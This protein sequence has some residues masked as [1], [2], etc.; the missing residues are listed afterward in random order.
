MKVL[1]SLL[2]NFAGDLLEQDP[3]TLSEHSSDLGLSVEE[4]VTLGAAFNGV[5]VAKVLDLRPH[6]DADR[7]QLVDVDDGSGTARQ[8]CC[9]A[10]NMQVGDLVPLATDG[11]VV[12]GG[13]KI[14]HRKLRGEWSEGMLCSAEE[15]ELPIS[16]TE[17][18]ILILPG[19]AELGSNVSEALDLKHDVLFDLEVNPNRPD[20]MSVAGVARV[21]AARLGLSFSIP[22]PNVVE[23]AKWLSRCQLQLMSPISVGISL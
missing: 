14:K 17:P 23:I 20:A 10:F 16:N 18:E 3:N 15:L 12:A 11:A 5:V 9:G 2:G 19:T 7:I 1:L 4:M 8:V 6:P 13:L 22:V 21:L